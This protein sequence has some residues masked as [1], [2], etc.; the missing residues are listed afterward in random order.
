MSHEEYWCEACD[1]ELA[2]ADRVCAECGAQV[3]RVHCIKCDGDSPTDAER[4]IHCWWP[5][6]EPQ[7]RWGEE[8]KARLASK[9][10][11]LAHLRDPELVPAFPFWKWLTM[12]NGSPG[13][14]DVRAEHASLH[15]KVFAW[16]DPFW[17]T[18]FPPTDAWCRCAV[19][20]LTRN[21]AEG[22]PIHTLLEVQNGCPVVGLLK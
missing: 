22:E 9:A 14:K 15:G 18:F 4:C 11:V 3:P 7:G 20:S 10:D 13:Y 16:D 2:V 21:Q 6:V 5:L 17:D 8:M 19:I 1:S 12:G